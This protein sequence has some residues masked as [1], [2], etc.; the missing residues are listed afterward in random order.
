LDSLVTSSKRVEEVLEIRE[1]EESGEV[2]GVDSVSVEVFADSFSVEGSRRGLQLQVAD[3]CGLGQHA[4]LLRETLHREEAVL[5][6]QSDEHGEGEQSGPS[7]FPLQS[8]LKYFAGFSV[9]D[10]GSVGSESQCTRQVTLVEERRGHALAPGTGSL[11]DE[12][13]LVEVD[14][15]VHVSVSPLHQVFDSLGVVAFVLASDRLAGHALEPVLSS[16]AVEC[17][18]FADEPVT[19]YVACSE[20]FEQQLLEDGPLTFVNHAICVEVCDAEQIVHLDLAH[21]LVLEQ[22]FPLVQSDYFLGLSHPLVF[23]DLFV[24]QNRELF[25][26]HVALWHFLGCTRSLLYHIRRSCI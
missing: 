2:N 6:G 23:A 14:G 22:G 7:L 9:G 18:T 5:L 13:V 12:D 8:F 20:V 15:S 19:R 11:A 26:S 16:E 10:D 17:L 21:P 1:I 4:V 25:A 3:E 24:R